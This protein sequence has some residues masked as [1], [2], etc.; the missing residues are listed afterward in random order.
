MRKSIFI[1][2]FFLIALPA[3]SENTLESMIDTYEKN[4]R[5]HLKAL[6][7]ISIQEM[8][9]DENKEQGL[10]ESLDTILKAIPIKQTILNNISKEALAV[11]HENPKKQQALTQ[12]HFADQPI[13]HEIEKSIAANKFPSLLKSNGKYIAKRMIKKI[14]A[15]NAISRKIELLVFLALND[16]NRKHSK[17]LTPSETQAFK[18]MVR[19]SIAKKLP[20]INA[21]KWSHSLSFLQET[22]LRAAYALIS[23]DSAQDILATFQDETFINTHLQLADSV[24]EAID[25]YLT[26]W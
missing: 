14:D 18:D 17:N 8:F 10:S 15:T 21:A 12:F 26:S 11:L 1:V 16:Y 3:F 19:R 7:E 25:A 2:V 9:S 23:S 6:G 20:T 5:S 4:I 24:N 22:E 13:L